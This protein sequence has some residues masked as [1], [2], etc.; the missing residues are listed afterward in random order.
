MQVSEYLNSQC[1]DFEASEC[2]G[3]ATPILAT[4]AA[5]APVVATFGNR[6]LNFKA[7]KETVQ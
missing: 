1:I 4:P 7:T 5:A 6:V 3:S 2:P